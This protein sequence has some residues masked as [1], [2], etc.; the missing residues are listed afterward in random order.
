MNAP[1][2]VCTARGGFFGSA[3]GRGAKIAQVPL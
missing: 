2:C 1:V 3:I